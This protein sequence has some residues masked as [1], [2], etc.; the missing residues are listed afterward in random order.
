VPIP[1]MLLGPRRCETGEGGD[2]VCEGVVA[3]AVD[4]AGT[5]ACQ[6]SQCAVGMVVVRA[7]HD[8]E[9]GGACHFVRRS[10]GGAGVK[11]ESSDLVCDVTMNTGAHAQ[12]IGPWDYSS[13]PPITTT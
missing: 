5:C 2:G 12:G 9:C 6:A 8:T 1:A 10:G 13:D 11:C 7:A 4:G 3:A